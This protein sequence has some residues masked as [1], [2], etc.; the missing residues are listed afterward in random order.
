MLDDVDRRHSTG[1]DLSDR[2]EDLDIVQVRRRI[3]H[4]HEYLGPRPGPRV[5]AEEQRLVPCP[6]LAVRVPHAHAVLVRLVT[7][8]AGAAEIVIQTSPLLPEHAPRRGD[9][10]AH[11]D[12]RLIL[13]D[14]DRIPG[15]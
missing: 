2:A 4:R 10:P 15:L 12:G 3:A 13:G 9:G 1:E 8:P 7:E 14:L 5:R 6:Y 11:L